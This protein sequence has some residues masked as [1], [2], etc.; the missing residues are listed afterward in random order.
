M[1]CHKISSCAGFTIVEALVAA[2]IGLL[3]F[4]LVTGF[5]GLYSLKVA[6]DERQKFARGYADSAF[7]T[8]VSRVRRSNRPQTLTANSTS[9]QPAAWTSLP[10]SVRDLG[11]GTIKSTGEGVTASA[12]Q[13]LTGGNGSVSFSPSVGTVSSLS[14]GLNFSLR[15]DGGGW[16]V[17][18]DGNTIQ[19]GAFN[20]GDR[21]RLSSFGSRGFLYQIRRD[22]TE[23]PLARS[24]GVF[25]SPIQFDV[26][27]NQNAMVRDVVLTNF[28]SL[29]SGAG[30][31]SLLADGGDTT[32]GGTCV[33]P[34]CAL[35]LLPPRVNGVESPPMI[36]D[37]AS[38]TAAQPDLQLVAVERFKIETLD[39]VRGLRK[40]TLTLAATR[41]A[42]PFVSLST[43]VVTGVDLQ[44]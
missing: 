38:S 18:E 28:D 24:R 21:F 10:A 20:D 5:L 7:T 14:A 15:V 25:G 3:A 29:Q 44:R 42:N 2:V 4:L 33:F 37:P 40:I 32:P 34:Y 30:T 35:V 17:I 36:V 6:L 13:K 19:S 31:E 8:L 39:A 23:S 41:D 12:S 43:Q 9:S 26:T 1:S 27:L 16:T 22:G 11:G